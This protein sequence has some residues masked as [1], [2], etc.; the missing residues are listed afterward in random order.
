MKRTLV[1]YSSNRLVEEQTAQSFAALV[2]AGAGLI[3]QRETAD[4]G[5][6]RNVALSMALLALRSGEHDV[7]LM[8]DDDVVFGV[9]QAQELVDQARYSGRPCSGAYVL[10]DG[11]LA[12]R[13]TG[14][15]WH[16]GLGFLAIPAPVLVALAATLPTFRDGGPFELTE[17]TYAKSEPTPEGGRSWLPE[18][19]R[20]C[21]N[22]G[23]VRLLPVCV[24]H[25]K[26]RLLYA[27]PET[28]PAFIAETERK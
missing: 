23:G 28:L 21:A 12:A 1:V 8:A 5:L 11:R 26:K 19:Y 22:L 20:L 15:T 3:A 4:V 25:V 6:A 17:F 16:T 27:N 7:V 24:A 10:A 14:E 13:W 2:A 9:G 18:D